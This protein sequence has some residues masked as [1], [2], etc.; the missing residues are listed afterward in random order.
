MMKTLKI[1]FGYTAF[2]LLY[3]IFSQNYI[4]AQKDGEDISIGTYR[5]IHSGILNEDRLLF[6]HLPQA[7][8]DTELSY[9]VLYLLWVDIH[10]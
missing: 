8:E 5:V 3:L 10:N 1:R 6:V 4:S 7:Y 9:P 2:L